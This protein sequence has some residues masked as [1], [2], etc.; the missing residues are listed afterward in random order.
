MKVAWLAG[1]LFLTSHTLAQDYPRKDFVLEKLADQIFPIQ[2]QDLNYEELYENFA[3]LLVNPL[4]LNSVTQEQLRSLLVLD[5]QEINAL[6]QYRQTAGRLLSVYELQSVPG[7]KR[8][9]FD[10]IIPFVTVHDQEAQLNASILSRLANEKNNYLVMRYDRTIETR[11][12]YSGTADSS[13]RYAGSPDRFLLR[14]RVSRS[15]DF[16]IGFTAE[17]DA[18]ENLLWLPER[19]QYGFDYISWHA[20]IQNKGSIRNLVLGDFQCQFGQGLVLGSSFGFGKNPETITSAR[21][22]NLGFLPYTSLNE[23]MALSGAAASVSLSPGILLHGFVSRTYLDANVDPQED[24]PSVSSWFASGLHRT[25]SELNNRKQVEETEAG[26][27]LQFRNRPFDSGLIFHRTMFSVP[28]EPNTTPY[29]QFSFRG[30]LLSNASL[31]VNYSWSNF[32]FFG[33]AA[34]TLGHGGAFTAGL[35]GNMSGKLELSLLIRKFDPDFYSFRSNAFSENTLPQNEQGL[36][37][38]FRYTASRK[39]A[40]MGYLDLF[41][42]PWL[43][44]RGY[45]V[46]EGSE[47]LMR[48]NYTPSKNILLFFQA[49]EESKIRNLPDNANLYQYDTGVKRNFWINCDYSALSVLTF[50]TRVQFSSYTLGGRSTTGLAVVQ[51]IGLSLNR[52]SFSTRFALFDTDDADNRAYM[53]ERDV[54][55]AF[56]FPAY[57]GTGVRNCLLVQYKLSR[58]V[59]L[60]FRWSSTRY[61]DRMEIGSAGERIASNTINDAK[62]QVRIRF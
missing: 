27:A 34:Q 46:S 44:Y 42:F 7:W 24:L 3:Q 58:Q 38:G 6:L 54:W 33:E 53:Y 8:T 9:T 25:A 32:T 21:R 37:W 50:K 26:G 39:Y 12:G 5:E 55:L 15:N 41:R 1:F 10:K 19:R 36:Y 59:D 20:Q 28:V 14:Y 51:D 61:T 48:F 16:S 11:K 47:W 13:Q 43:R 18:G 35:L 56:S 22:S 40:V 52:W 2:D 45:A 60:W 57:D 4:D 23:S 17:K 62:F 30:A 29:N 31:Y 49:R